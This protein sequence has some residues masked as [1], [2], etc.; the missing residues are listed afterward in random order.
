MP[1]TVTIANIIF[2]DQIQPYTSTQVLL[3]CTAVYIHAAVNH[4]IQ[5]ALLLTH[6]SVSWPSLFTGSPFLEEL[7][8]IEHCIL[9]LSYKTQFSG[10]AMILSWRFHS[11]IHIL[12][13]ITVLWCNTV[14]SRIS[15]S[16]IIWDR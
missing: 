11:M 6:M 7:V 16:G 12:E 8:G 3:W 9:E 4:S 10:G 1:V 2:S 15:N 5:E 13:N 14:I